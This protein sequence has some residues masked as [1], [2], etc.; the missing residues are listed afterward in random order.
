MYE[1]AKSLL[2]CTE[3]TL[4]EYKHLRRIRQEY[5]VVQG[6]YANR[7]K[8]E[9]ISII[10][11]SGIIGGNILHVTKVLNM[12][13]LPFWNVLGFR[14][15]NMFHVI[16]F[17][18]GSAEWSQDKTVAGAFS[19]NYMISNLFPRLDHIFRILLRKGVGGMHTRVTQGILLGKGVGGMHTR[20]TQGIL[21]GKGVGGMHTRVT[22]GIWLRKG[23][24]GMHTRVTQG[25]LLRKGVGGMHTIG[26]QCNISTCFWVFGSACHVKKDSLFWS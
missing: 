7:H 1:Y 20:V 13:I 9:P 24:G 6:E 16:K 19:S 18:M 4:K 10:I 8:I 11:S 3:I 25:I 17:C 26:S 21:L 12:I 23:V 2:A 5:F 22:Q 15:K 14:W